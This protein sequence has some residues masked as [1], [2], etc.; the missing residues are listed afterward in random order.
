MVEL[1]LSLT[2]RSRTTNQ[3]NVTDGRLDGHRRA[4]SLRQRRNAIICMVVGRLHIPTH[5]PLLQARASRWQA[6]SDRAENP[7]HTVIYSNFQYCTP[8][9][10]AVLKQLT[11]H[12][13][14]PVM[15][16]IDHII[17]TT[18]WTVI[19]KVSTFIRISICICKWFLPALYSDACVCVMRDLLVQKDLFPMV[20]SSD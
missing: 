9:T 16:H 1:Y 7:S 14:W 18:V 4:T 17:L 12:S 13:L 3:C 5:I 2:R 10:G 8:H 19:R 11:L 15:R 20:K 6:T